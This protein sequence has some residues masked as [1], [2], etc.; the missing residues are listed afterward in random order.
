MRVSNG[1]RYEGDWN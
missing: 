1:T